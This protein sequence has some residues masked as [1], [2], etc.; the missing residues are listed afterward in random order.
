MNSGVSGMIPSIR[1]KQD[2]LTALCQEY[3]V[4]TLELFGSATDEST[5][6]AHRSD[7][8]FLVE[9][10]PDQ[11]L[12]P[13]MGHFF[14]FKEALQSLFG[15]DVDLV[16]SS[17][18]KRPYFVQEVNRTRTMLYAAESTESEVRR[19]AIDMDAGV[20]RQFHQVDTDIRRRYSFAAITVSD[21]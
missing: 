10:I 1:E 8:D 6:D 9:F 2:E 4:R 14:R 11:Q 15:R 7:L 17:A 19:C 20:G 13:W 16:M 12:G 3:G 21:T 18:P 5:F